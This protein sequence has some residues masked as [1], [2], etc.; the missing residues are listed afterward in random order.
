MKE[1]K[2]MTLREALDSFVIHSSYRAAR[3]KPAEYYRILDQDEQQRTRN[4]AGTTN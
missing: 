3:R 1:K 4:G 2:V